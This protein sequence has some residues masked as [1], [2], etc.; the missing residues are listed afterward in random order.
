M[1][2]KGKFRTF[3]ETIN[4]EPLLAAAKLRRSEVGNLGTP[5]PLNL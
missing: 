1:T 3:Y 5:E 4:L 2:E